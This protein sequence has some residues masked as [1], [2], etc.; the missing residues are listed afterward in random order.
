MQKKALTGKHG[1]DKAAPQCSI[2]DHVGFGFIAKDVLYNQWF[3]LLHRFVAK[4][5]SHFAAV[6]LNVK[7]RGNL[8]ITSGLLGTFLDT[9]GSEPSDGVL[10]VSKKQHLPSTE[11]M[12][13]CRDLVPLEDIRHLAAL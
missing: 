13:T 12:F 4:S 10:W 3:C 2:I 11:D 5:Y 8:N 7:N 6:W 9:H 1:P